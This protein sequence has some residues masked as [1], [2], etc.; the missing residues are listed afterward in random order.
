M[1]VVVYVNLNQ[2]MN[3][4]T[5][6]L[7]R[8]G[9]RS[10]LGRHARQG[11]QLRSR[12]R[13]FRKTTGGRPAA[14]GTQIPNIAAGEILVML[15]ALARTAAEVEGDLRGWVVRLRDLGIGWDLIAATLQIGEEEARQRFGLVPNH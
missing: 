9:G 8:T 12:R 15:P 11:T 1:N 5:V 4:F 6:S 13:Q 14:P 2:S 3:P 7:P 10:G